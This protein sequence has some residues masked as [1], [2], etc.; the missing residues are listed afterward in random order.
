MVNVTISDP[1]ADPQLREVL[2]AA[3]EQIRDQVETLKCHYHDWPSAVNV[4]IRDDKRVRF[5]VHA[6]CVDHQNRIEE[7]LEGE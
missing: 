6:C 7:L 2:T 1:P 4:E 3:A 5:H